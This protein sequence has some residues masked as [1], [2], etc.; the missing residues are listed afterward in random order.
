MK[1]FAYL[2]LVVITIFNS[3]E[4]EGGFKTT[5]ETFQDPRDGQEYKNVKIGN[6]IWMAENLNYATDSGSWIYDN[7]SSNAVIYGRLY[8]WE[9]ACNVCPDGWHLSSDEDWQELEVYLGMDPGEIILDPWEQV[10]NI[11]GDMLKATNGWDLNGNGTN[12]TGFS[13][14]PGGSRNTLSDQP[15]FANIGWD[16]FYWSPKEDVDGEWALYRKLSTSNRIYRSS[17]PKTD[18]LSVRCIKDE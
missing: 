14:L 18:G 16:A 17:K 12:S 1:K 10:N 4:E 11:I 13:A 2:I 7:D 5:F 8:N 6:Q 9:T 3:C 15:Y